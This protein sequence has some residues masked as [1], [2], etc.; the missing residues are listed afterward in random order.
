MLIKPVHLREVIV[1][2][3]FFLE[4]NLIYIENI[5]EEPL[6]ESELSQTAYQRLSEKYLQIKNL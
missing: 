2:R 4:V 6:R 3:I 5:P 1:L